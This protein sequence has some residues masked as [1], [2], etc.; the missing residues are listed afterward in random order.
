[1]KTITN[2]RPKG[3]YD[4][5]NQKGELFLKTRDLFFKLASNF[6]FNFI[7]T[8]IFEYL[9]VFYTSGKQSDLVSK[10]L[11]KFS[12]RSE[13]TMALRAE[14]TAPVMRAIAE[15]KLFLDNKK[16]FYFGQMFRYEKPQKGRSRQFWQA[17]CE[18]IDLSDDSQTAAYQKLEILQLGIT[19]LNQLNIDYKIKLNYLA[20]EQTRQKY[21]EALKQYFQQYKD[22]LEKISQQ[23][24]EKNPL[25]ILDDKIESQKDFVINAP[26][27]DAFYLEAEK[28]DFETILAV[29]KDNKIDFEVDTNLVRGLDYYDDLVFEFVSDSPALGQRTTILG[30]GCYY[31]LVS[32]FQMPAAKGVGFAIGVDRLLEI[33]SLNTQNE[34]TIDFY[35]LGFNFDE[36]KTFAFLANQIRQD[37]FTAE[38]NKKPTSF[39]KG[40]KKA[41]KTNAKLIV[42][43]EKDQPANTV[44]IK[45]VS[46]GEKQIV[47][48]SSSAIT[49]LLK[50]NNV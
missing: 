5:F 1:M 34:R 21:I 28:Q 7:D 23:R 10:E 42:F 43:Y 17:G 13:R 40:F 24:L 20:T 26:K 33:L 6:N 39:T 19:L 46:T 31:N 9:T 2:L 50:E 25:R 8:P 15:N 12:D 4:L 35:F 16:F 32:D 36:I 11:Y 22:K 37:N 44:T 14:G 45:T 41:Q 30:G 29:L 38:F 48:F 27:I 49:K 3:T 18:F 47:E